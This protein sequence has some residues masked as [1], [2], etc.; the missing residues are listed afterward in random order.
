MAKPFLRVWPQHYREDVTVL[1]RS[2]LLTMSGYNNVVSR[3]SRPLTGLALSLGLM[4][5]GIPHLSAQATELSGAGPTAISSNVAIMSRASLPPQRLG[6]IY[7]EAVL[8]SSDTTAFP[9]DGIYLYGQSTQPD[10]I[11]SSYAVMEIVGN[12][13]I[14]AFYMPQSSFDCFYGSVGS[15]NLAL[16]VVSSYD[17]EVHPYALSFQDSATVAAV[18]PVSSAVQLEGYHEISTVSQNDHRILG[19]CRSNLQEHVTQL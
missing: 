1:N 15:D 6:Q 14:G 11:G 9:N 17:D 13:A 3:L 4:L 19:V 10:Q 7:S 12:Q 18:R 5:A 8:S 2:K 16:N